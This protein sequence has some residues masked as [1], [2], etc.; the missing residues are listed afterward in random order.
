MSKRSGIQLCYPFEEKR[1]SKWEPPYIIQP[2]LDGER[3]RAIVENG[4]VVLLSSELN[5]FKC[6][7]HINKSVEK[8]NLPEHT[9]LDGELYVHGWSF[10][11]IHSVV[12]RTVNI[13]QEYHKMEFHIF[14]WLV[15]G[16]LDKSQGQRINSLRY[17]GFKSPLIPVPYSIATNLEEIM[18]SYRSLLAQNYEGIIIRNLFH[19]YERRRSTGIMKF[20][21]KKYDHYQILECLEAIDKNGVAKNTLGAFL[22]VGTDGTQFKV[23]A[24]TLTHKERDEIWENRDSYTSMA[25]EVQYQNITSNGVPRFGLCF[26]KPSEVWETEVSPFEVLGIR[27]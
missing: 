8:L 27:R 20:K 24:G 13:H 9:E 15:A 4:Q 3:C 5:E 25:C 11:E 26:K 16:E 21:P 2:K 10:E 17:A 18:I 23:G 22:C 14:D 19:P 7:P 12:S 1:L 6:L